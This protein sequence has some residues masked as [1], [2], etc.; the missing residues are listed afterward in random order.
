ML[1]STFRRV[2]GAGRSPT[3]RG[4]IVSPARVQIR[5]GISSPDDHLTA[6]PDCREFLSA[7]GRVWRAGGCPV[8][9]ARIVSPAGVQKCDAI[10]SAPD[11]HFSPTPYRL[12][13]LPVIGPAGAYCCCTTICASA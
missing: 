11:D 5:T 12:V 6:G 10:I 2:G 7:N 13:V 1:V 3:I 9:R 4:W 8:V